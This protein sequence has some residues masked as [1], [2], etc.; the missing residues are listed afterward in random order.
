MEINYEECFYFLVIVNS[1]FIF[2][3]YF[4]I[5]KRR[6]Y[7]IIKQKIQGV[8]LKRKYLY[9]IDVT[10]KIDAIKAIDN[11]KPKFVFYFSAPTIANLY[12]INNWI[13]HLKSCEINFFIMIRELHNVKELLKTETNIPIVWAKTMR[14]IELFLPS[15][16]ELVIYANNSMKNTHIV[17]FS[18]LKHIQLLHGDSEKQSS[19]N[20]ISKMYDKLFVAGQR[21]ID[22]YAE[23]GVKIP[24]DSFEIIGRPQLSNIEIRNDKESNNYTVLLAPTWAGYY[25]DANFSS[26]FYLYDVIEYL[27]KFNKNI[28]FILRLHPLIDIEEKKTSEYLNK[29]EL[30]LKNNDENLLYSKRDIVEDF[31]DSD[32]IVTDTSSVP[33]DYLYSEKPI[34]HI[35]VNNL[36][37]NFKTEIKYDKYKNCSYM[38]NK[39]ISNIENIF[40]QVFNNDILLNERQISKSYYHGKFDISLDEVFKSKVVQLLENDHD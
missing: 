25:E 30:L 12:H 5:R 40:D 35:D 37:N 8:I 16:L 13:S 24:K 29:L 31:N 7:K 28:C 32:C 1:F 4:S 17:R 21:A 39:K 33:I 22:R 38:I 19:Y 18:H 23:H 2:I 20:P 11:Y 26:L 6:I 9:N 34:I 36:S 10:N 3:L 15:S 14:D 27:I